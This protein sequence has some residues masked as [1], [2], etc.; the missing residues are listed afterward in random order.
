V[1]WHA[2]WGTIWQPKVSLL[3]LLNR[4]LLLLVRL[5]LQPLLDPRAALVMPHDAQVH[6]CT[7][8]KTHVDG[9][10]LKIS[11]KHFTSGAGLLTAYLPD[12]SC[13]NSSCF[14]NCFS[15]CKHTDT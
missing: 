10:Q 9:G 15:K 1:S 11:S 5:L 3:L 14:S 7:N 2:A 12:G 4:L 13:D 6:V 8:T